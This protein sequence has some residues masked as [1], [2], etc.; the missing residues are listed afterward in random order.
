[1]VQAA[2]EDHEFGDNGGQLVACGGD[3]VAVPVRE[4]A[5]DAAQSGERAVGEA[6]FEE[7][8]LGV[9]GGE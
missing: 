1:M 8:A 3:G 2:G 7:L 9:G 4:D 5:V 6:G